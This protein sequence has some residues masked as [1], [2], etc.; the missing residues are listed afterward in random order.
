MRQLVHIGSVVRALAAGINRESRLA[1]SRRNNA[2]AQVT[3][4]LFYNGKRFPRAIEG[5]EAAVDATFAPT[6]PIRA[7]FESFVAMRRVA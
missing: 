5:D 3:D 2:R 7:I 1:Q 6:S 4:V